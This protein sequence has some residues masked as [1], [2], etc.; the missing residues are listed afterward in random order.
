MREKNLISKPLNKHKK[1]RAPNLW[2]YTGTVWHVDWKHLD[3]GRYIIC[4]LDNITDVIE[5]YGIFD[6]PT[7]KNLKLVLKEIIKEQGNPEII[8]AYNS[9]SY[10]ASK[11]KF[12]KKEY[13]Q[14][15]KELVEQN[16]R[17]RPN[18]HKAQSEVSRMKEFYKHV[19]DVRRI[20]HMDI[21]DIIYTYNKICLGE[22]DLDD[23]MPVITLTA[24][25]PKPKTITKQTRKRKK[26]NVKS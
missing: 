14:F 23:Y 16:I 5:G 22:A 3:D 4:F 20:Y 10:Y 19:L 21:P 25:K 13:M 1:R 18:T 9:I 6:K 11:S 2:V 26:S 17:Y 8:T 12:E 7:I 15:K 24:K